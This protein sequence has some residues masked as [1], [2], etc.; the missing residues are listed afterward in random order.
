MKNDKSTDKNVNISK[1]R[2][3]TRKWFLAVEQLYET[4]RIP[5]PITVL[6]D[7]IGTRLHLPID[8]LIYKL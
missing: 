4:T 5:L 7:S 3:E 6:L 1:S 2:L 8:K